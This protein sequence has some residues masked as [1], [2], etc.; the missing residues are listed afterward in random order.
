MEAKCSNGRKNRSNKRN[1]LSYNF[2]FIGLSLCLS[3]FLPFQMTYSS[4]DQ[5]SYDLLVYRNESETIVEDQDNEIITRRL[6]STAAIQLGIQSLPP[7][8]VMLITGGKYDMI[9]TLKLIPNI[10][11][12]GSNS[13]TVLDFSSIGNKNVTVE[14]ARGS[15][16]S[17]ITISGPEIQK[18]LPMDFTHKLKV[19]DDVVIERVN[20]QNLAYGIETS[21]TTGVKLIDIHCENIRS[22]NDWGVCIHAGGKKTSDLSVNGVTVVN[23]N[24]G[25]EID[26]P[27]SGIT[28][29]NGYLENIKNFAGTGNSAF[30]IDVHSHEGEG[31]NSD[32]TYRNIYL[33]NTDAPSAYS[34]GSNYFYDRADQP[35]DVLF[36]NITV[37]NPRNPWYVNAQGI[38]IKDC[39]IVNSTKSIIVINKNSKDVVIDSVEATELH[40]D[41]FFIS[42]NEYHTGQKGIQTGV[43][44]VEILNSTVVVSSDKDGPGPVMSFH[45]VDGLTLKNNIIMNAKHNPAILLED[46]TDLEEEDNHVVKSN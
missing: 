4:L 36:E 2:L 7:E 19:A 10:S 33:N 11:V 31:S 44:D 39:K 37:E 18:E 9:D 21:N 38:T 24:R 29:E 13:N 14:M 45:G 26:A 12:K 40:T 32:I 25:I 22:A 35:R 17:D 42:N 41:K 23:S 43:E 30:S 28:V 16:L 8:G 27:S 5:S 15:T 34:V 46:V 1:Q 3:L 6:D 20:V